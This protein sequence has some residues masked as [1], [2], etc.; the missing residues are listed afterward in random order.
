[1]PTNCCRKR[2]LP[3]PRNKKEQGRE[4]GT[5]NENQAGAGEI[6]QRRK[7]RW[8]RIKRTK[9]YESEKRD[10]AIKTSKRRNRRNKEESR[11]GR[12]A[13]KLRKRKK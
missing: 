8:Q 2:P 6:E 11:V 10:E 5:H 3:Y 13:G 4:Q 1:M 9:R 12:D 7:F